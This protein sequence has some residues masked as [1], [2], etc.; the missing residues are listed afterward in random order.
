MHLWQIEQV[1]IEPL[2]EIVTEA[3]DTEEEVLVADLD[4]EKN[5]AVRNQWQFSCAR[6]PDQYG[7]ITKD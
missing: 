1:G 4:L 7:E 2:G 6:R 5:R 3:G